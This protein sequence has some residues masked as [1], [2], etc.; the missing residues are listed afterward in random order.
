MTFKTINAVR[1][2]TEFLCN[3]ASF[4]RYK[5]VINELDFVTDD[6]EWFDRI[7]LSQDIRNG[8]MQRENNLNLN[9]SASAGAQFVVIFVENS[10]APF[11]LH[12]FNFWL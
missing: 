9:N 8:Y 7:S 5:L 4:S 10:Y 3:I 2:T 1:Q 12:Y 11:L 6:K